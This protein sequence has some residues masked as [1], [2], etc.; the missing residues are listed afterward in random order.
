M[1]MKFRES[2]DQ[3]GQLPTLRKNLEKGRLTIDHSKSLAPQQARAID[4]VLTLRYHLDSPQ[5][6]TI[7]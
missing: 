2:R 1:V 6:P 7:T 5:L 3:T 4:T